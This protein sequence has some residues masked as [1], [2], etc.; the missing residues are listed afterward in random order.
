LGFERA[1]LVAATIGGLGAFGA[2]AGGEG[3]VEPSYGRIEG[4]MTIVAGAGAVVTSGGPRATGELRLRY[5]ETVGVFGAYE[6]GDLVGSASDP[7]RA[8]SAGFELRPLFLYRWLQGLETRRARWDLLLDSL[9]LELGMIWVEPKEAPFATHP[10]LEAGLGIEFPIVP[11]AS[12]PWIGV[13]GGARW[14]DDMLASG[15]ARTGEDR[16]AYLS[17]TLAW[18]Q[19]I[20]AHVVD[21]GDRALP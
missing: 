20:A 2:D 5:L 1:V 8:V 14:G 12:G 3:I 6:D 13:H 9:G 7:R 18:H 11:A 19:V 21:V 4:D 10:G 15:M 16:E 17:I